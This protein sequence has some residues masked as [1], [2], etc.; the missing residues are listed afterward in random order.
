MT[1]VSL[2]RGKHK[3]EGEVENREDLLAF[4][5]FNEYQKNKIYVSGILDDI[6]HPPMYSHKL[7]EAPLG[8][9]GESVVFDNDI[10]DF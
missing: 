8:L 6:N 1:S 3:L 7:S 10:E 4:L 5:W 9:R 2:L